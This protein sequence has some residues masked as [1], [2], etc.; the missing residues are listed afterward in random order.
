MKKTL[1]ITTFM[2]ASL[3]SFGQLSINSFQV[4]SKATTKVSPMPEI[5]S[6]NPFWSE[7]FANGI[8][9]TWTNSTAPWVYRGPSTNPGITTGSQGAYGTNSGTI[10]SSTPT[11]G[12][13]IF[14][15][16]YYDNNGV[17]GAFGTGM[18]PTPHNGELMTDVIDLSMY[19]DVMIRMNSYF[20]TFAGQAFVRFYVNG[21]L[22]SEVQV[23]ADLDVND[24]SPDDGVA[25][26][27]FPNTVPGNSNVQMAFIFEGTTNLVNSMGGYYFWML[28]D[29]E[30]I[31]TPAHLMTVTDVKHGGWNSIPVS[32]GFSMDYTFKPLIQSNAN[33][34]TF[35]MILANIG[36]DDLTGARM[37]I[38][39][40]DDINMQVFSSNSVANT[41]VTL[42][43]ALYVA[44]QTYAPA[45]MGIYNM[46]FW[47]SSDSIAYTDTTYMQAIITDSVYGRDYGNPAG[48]WRVGR[49][50]GGL[51]VGN[52][53]DVYA[54][55]DLTSV[56][57]YVADYSVAGATM[58][59][60]LYEVDTTSSPMSFIFLD[61]T[62]NY[63]IQ[64]A[65]ID[66]W[67]TIPFNSAISIDPQLGQ[68]YMIAIGGYAH[69]IDTFGISVS[70]E[71]EVTMSR[72]Q[73]NGCNLGSQGF[74]YWYWVSETPMVRM[75]F[76]TPSIPASIKETSFNEN[77]SIYPN[78]TNGIF[79]VEIRDVQ[80]DVYTIKVTN[81][82]GQMIFESTNSIN[83]IYKE[84][85]DLSA[86]QKGVYL[87]GINNSTTTITER[88][89]VE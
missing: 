53:F 43:T 74:G 80:T 27:R 32:Q 11:N 37:N 4:E 10:T 36:A 12:F 6:A 30:L 3:L 26:V 75:N 49:Q 29:I 56:S 14:D 17:V 73:D 7:D 39:V 48:S 50:C 59:G 89:I 87:I 79:T 70:G 40:Y 41:L 22:D 35:E 5:K 2:L 20:R 88:I 69:P 45:N 76:G 19:S 85:I 28:D 65:D 1:H 72:I 66:A 42:D 61:Q 44:Q 64:T 21:V 33:P 63:T 16:D 71:A 82:L 23:H 31:E 68:Q 81:V 52:I 62:D 60:V 77:L 25:L 55:D 46:R 78:P 24:S 83:G 84:N 51:Q 67:V 34:Y 57:A 13:I 9:T 15:S 18:Y 38:E 54:T 47:G 86:F 8:P 58:F